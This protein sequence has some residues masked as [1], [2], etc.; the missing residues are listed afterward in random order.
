MDPTLPRRSPLASGT[1]GPAGAAS[2]GAALADPPAESVDLAPGQRLAPAQLGRLW[3][4]QRGVVALTLAG[5]GALLPSP[6]PHA[7]PHALALPGDLVGVECL[8]PGAAPPAV[9]AMTRATLVPVLRPEAGDPARAARAAEARAALLAEAYAQARRQAFEL[10]PLRSGAAGERVR[11]LLVLLGAWERRDNDALPEVP[12]L[13]HVAGLID[14][15]PETVCR[16]LG[17]MRALRLLPAGTSRRA[18]AAA[19]A[20]A[21]TPDPIAT[22]TVTATEVE[23]APLSA[24]SSTM[25]R[26]APAA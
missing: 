24:R 14:S 12:M 18:R 10:Q 23:A 21:V 13:R 8:T 19:A 5:G 22:S 15:S 26:R 25:G 17:R 16:I 20:S 9:E 1:H 7:L 2:A 3:R 11:A 4:V 6:L